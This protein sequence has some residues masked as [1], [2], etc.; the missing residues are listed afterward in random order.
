MN[1]KLAPIFFYQASVKPLP[2]LLK[3]KI[4]SNFF[5]PGFTEALI[6]AYMALLSLCGD[7]EKVVPIFF[8][9]INFK[10]K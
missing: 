6:A 9:K 8:Y 1:T 3:S 7:K 10:S 4:G 2:Q 5:L